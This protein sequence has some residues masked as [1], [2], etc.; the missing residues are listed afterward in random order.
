MA[1]V[2]Q[3]P[4]LFLKRHGASVWPCDLQDRLLLAPGAKQ[5]R[6]RLFAA[7]PFSRR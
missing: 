6:G 7:Q 5:Q 3:R 2:S 1:G 4:A